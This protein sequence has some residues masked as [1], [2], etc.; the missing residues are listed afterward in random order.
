[1]GSRSGCLMYVCMHNLFAIHSFIPS[2]SHSI[3]HICSTTSMVASLTM[4]TFTLCPSS[5]PWPTCLV[6]IVREFIR[7]IAFF[8]LS[9]YP[10]IYPHFSIH[11]KHHLCVCC[12]PDWS[13]SHART[14]HACV[15][16][17]CVLHLHCQERRRHH[18][19]SLSIQPLS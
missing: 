5:L 19:K 15:C 17:V 11:R 9:I 8:S 2:S 4:S 1:M 14:V 12:G 16:S 13:Q 10:S 6:R 18:R 3:T 7:F